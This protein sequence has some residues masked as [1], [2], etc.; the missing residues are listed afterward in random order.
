M[1]AVALSAFATYLGAQ[2]LT[3][4]TTLREVWQKFC[5][6]GFSIWGVIVLAGGWI[7][8]LFTSLVG[9][10]TATVAAI[11]NLVIPS[12]GVQNTL[13]TFTGIANTFFPL[14][15]CMVFLVAYLSLCLALTIYRLAK[16]WIPTLS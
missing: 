14:Q 10:V 3:G 6:F 4:R 13:A 5:D 11:A 7:Y 2:L 9:H 16:S 1:V 8:Y 12:Q 15:E